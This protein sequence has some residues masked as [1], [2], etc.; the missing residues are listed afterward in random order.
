M[1]ATALLIA[2]AACGGSDRESADAASN[3]TAGDD[4]GA[5]ERLDVE[6]LPIASAL[7]G[8]ATIGDRVWVSDPTGAALVE[9][10][11]RGT[12]LRTV[13][14]GA[15]DPRDAGLA[16]DDA[17]RIWVA[18]LGGTV[19]A[20]D[21]ATGALGDRVE[22]SPG[23]PAAVAVA[24]GR[25]WVPRHGDGG[26][27]AVLA[28][29]GATPSKD[30]PVPF[31]GFAVAASGGEVW[32][33]GLDAGLVRVGAGGEVELEIDLPGAPRGVAVVGRDVWV[34][35]AERGEIVRV[36]GQTGE[37]TARV[38]VGGTPWPVAAGSGA[39]WVATLEGN[40]LRVDPDAA[41]IT[42]DADVAPQS[43]GVAIGAG[44]VWVTS[45]TGVLSRVALD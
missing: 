4:E 36:D 7:W 35:L 39:L 32:V 3:D 28:V 15:P 37:T 44:A 23:E 24:A 40:L 5:V 34:S 9:L 17:G 41:T 27:L 11:A 21:S 10:D 26:G 13:R 12:P 14:T 43:R 1:V 25:V 42:G 38:D 22:V 19:A 18:N 2:S 16:I 45:Q 29:D 33:T 31:D 8:V 20:V 6:Q 30:V